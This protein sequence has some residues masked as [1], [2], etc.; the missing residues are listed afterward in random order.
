[1]IIIIVYLP[2]FSLIL[3]EKVSA[4]CLLVPFSL[5][6]KCEQ[7]YKYIFLITK[8]NVKLLLWYFYDCSRIMS[9]K[10]IR[11]DDVNTFICI[12]QISSDNDCI[13]PCSCIMISKH[14]LQ[15]FTV[16]SK[17]N[18]NVC[19]S[20]FRNRYWSLHGFP[21]CSGFISQLRAISDHSEKREFNRFALSWKMW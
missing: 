12:L 2:P 1:M 4:F 10:I 17:W 8:I 13:N 20:P 9:A 14:G 5:D 21:C 16:T 11:P 6:K 15:P 18:D 3:W 7:W 19:T